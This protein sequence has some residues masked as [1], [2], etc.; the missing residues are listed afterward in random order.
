[1]GKRKKEKTSALPQL[2]SFRTRYE[3][4]TSAAGRA[5][6]AFRKV[7]SSRPAQASTSS[8]EMTWGCGKRRKTSA[9]GRAVMAFRKVFSSRCARSSG[10]LVRNDMGLWKKEKNFCGGQSG[11]GFPQKFSPHAALDP[12]QVR[13]K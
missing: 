13:S 1:M 3:E 2:M 4:K 7:F 5:V 6:M 12:P 11:D 9:A 10:K 8:F